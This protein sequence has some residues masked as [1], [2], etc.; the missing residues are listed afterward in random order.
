MVGL[1]VGVPRLK[2]RTTYLE[3]ESRRFRTLSSISPSHGLRQI[4]GTWDAT[5]ASCPFF[6]TVTT[7]GDVNEVLF[8]S[9]INE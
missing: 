6:D 9:N 8:D 2:Q 5:F 7:S 1:L 4:T 3:I